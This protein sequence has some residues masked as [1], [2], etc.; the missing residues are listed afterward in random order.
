[1]SQNHISKDTTQENVASLMI[2]YRLYGRKVVIVG[3]GKVAAER[4]QAA[5]AAG[6]TVEL[7]APAEGLSSSLAALVEAGKIQWT[8][9]SYTGTEEDQRLLRSADMVLSTIDDPVLSEQIGNTC[10]DA[11]VPV[12]C[13][14]VPHLCDFWFMS[15]HRDGP[16]Q[17]GVSTNGNGPRLSS[18]I[19]THLVKSLPAG[20]GEAVTRLGYLRQIIRLQDPDPTSVLLPLINLS[21]KLNYVNKNQV[22]K[23]MKWL[24]ELCNSTSIETLAKMNEEQVENLLSQYKQQEAPVFPKPRHA[25]FY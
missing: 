25:L 7:L 5:L 9:R 12:N 2:A 15:V 14:D 23:R 24:T 8:N 21:I 1:M 20:A 13:A 17:I 11:R 10:H 6:A 4:T 22:G 19:R 16:L 3:G 18:L